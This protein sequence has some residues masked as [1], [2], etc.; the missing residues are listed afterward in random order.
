MKCE[1]L[2]SEENKED[3]SLL[4]IAIQNVLNT[5]RNKDDNPLSRG[6]TSILAKAKMVP[7]PGPS[8]S[9]HH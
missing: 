8:C 7:K 5:Q 3:I 1:S 2:F 6:H 9:K 4:F